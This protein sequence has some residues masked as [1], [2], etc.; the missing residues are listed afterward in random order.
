M[1]VFSFVNQRLCLYRFLHQHLTGQDYKVFWLL[2]V[3]TFYCPESFVNSLPK[4]FLQKQV[5]L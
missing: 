5:L 3:A 1:L 2:F 4:S